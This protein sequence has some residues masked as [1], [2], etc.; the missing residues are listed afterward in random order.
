MGKRKWPKPKKK[1]GKVICPVCGN[2]TK[3]Q[4][5]YTGHY[6]RKVKR[7]DEEH[8]NA[9]QQFSQE[10]ETIE[11]AEALETLER[12]GYT[13]IKEQRKSDVERNVDLQPFKG[14]WYKVGLISDAHLGSKYQQ[15]THLH[16]AYEYFEEQGVDTVLN[17]GDIT[18][19]QHVY[20]GQEMEL[21]KHGADAQME[22]AIEMY[23]QKEGITT[24]FITGNHDE[25]HY[26]RAGIKVGKWIGKSREDMEYLG[27]HGATVKVHG[28]EFY[29]M[30]G[31]GGVAYARSY[32][33]QKIIEQIAPG[34]KPHF[35]ILGHFHVQCILPRY[36]NVIGVQMPCFQAQTP[37]LKAKGKNPEVG[38]FI[39][40]FKIDEEAEPRG[41][42]DLRVEPVPFYRTIEEDY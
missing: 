27:V 9:F 1:N 10:Q 34:D 13:V 36:R 42:G 38:A 24:Y 37:Y 15:I 6:R 35:L 20:R 32:K 39:M 18:D 25:K 3:T 22:Y 7:G 8:I 31:S 26:K 11:E 14:D 28:I 29:L 19:G 40:E 16:T 21:F 2:T 12:E 17:A 4:S 30:H 33:L 41:I 5:G 23:P